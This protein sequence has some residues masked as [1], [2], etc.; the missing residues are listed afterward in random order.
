MV[1][2]DS[3]AKPA[4]TGWPTELQDIDT[5]LNK[6]SFLDVFKDH[7]TNDIVTKFVRDVVVQN[8]QGHD[9]TGDGR[10]L[11]TGDREFRRQA[12]RLGLASLGA[13]LQAN[14]TGPVLEGTDTSDAVF[15]SAYQEAIRCTKAPGAN[16]V[17]GLKRPIENFRKLCVRSLD[18]D[19]VSVYPYIPHIELFGFARFIFTSGNILPVDPPEA[20]EADSDDTLA[21]DLS[22]VRFRV[23]LW[24]YKLL[25][26]PSLGPGSL[27]TKSGRWTDV[28]TL[29]ETIQKSLDDVEASVTRV[30]E[31]EEGV[32]TPAWSHEHRIQFY[33]EKANAHLMLGSDKAARRALQWAT[34]KSGFVYALSGALG[35][36]TRFQEKDISQLVVLAK[37]L[38]ITVTDA[39][40]KTS[41]ESA[42]TAL[43]LNDDTLLERIDFKNESGVAEERTELPVQL[44]DI[45]PDNQPKLKPEDQII[46][47]TEATLKDT[48][49][50]SDALT[51]EEIL[52]FAVRVIDDKASNWQ[53]Y[54]Q[55][56][57]VRSRIELN[58][59]RTLERAV[60][61]MQAVVDQVIVDTQAPALA[62]ISKDAENRSGSNTESE[63]PLIEI[64]TTNSRPTGSA[65][66][67]KPTS[68]LPAPKHSESASAQERLQYVN[69]LA[70]PP[71]WHLESELAYAW[72][73]V[74]SLVS[75]T[76]IFKRLRLWAEVALCLASNA[77]S[78]DDRDAR[79]SGGEEKAR[80]IVRWRLFHRT[81]SRPDS[82]DDE[83]DLD[84]V[85]VDI[86]TLK[87]SDFRGPERSPAPPNAPRLF[88]ILG[89]LE[90]NPAHYE[91]AWEISNRRFARAQRS[92]GELYLRNQEW[93]KA[94]DAYA[95]AV[96]VNR[97]SPEMWSRLGD[98]ELRLGHFPDA[99]EAF[100]RAISTAGS[101][102]EG[103]EDARTWSNLGSALLSWYREA[104][105]ENKAS[106]EM[107]LKEESGDDVYDSDAK[108]S[109]RT[110]DD[111]EE[112]I[113]PSTAR[114]V[115][116]GK[117]PYKLLN[118]A[119]E[120]FKRGATIANSNWRIWDNVV[121]LAASLCPS[122]GFDDVILG[123]RN[124][125][126]I[127]KT[128]DALDV[129]ILTLLVRE[130]TGRA[131]GSGEGVGAV[132][133]PPRASLER[134]VIDLFE[135][136]VVPLLTATS[137][138]WSLVSR[139]RAWRRDWTGALEAAE[140]G[141]RAA[142]SGSGAGVSGD[143]GSSSLAP[144][145]AVSS[146]PG[147]AAAADWLQDAGAWDAVVQRT[148]EL[149]AAYENYGDK[150]ESVGSRWK[151]KARM[152]VRSVLGKGRESW[153]GSD[154]WRVLE[155]LLEELKG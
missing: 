59:S 77:N 88:C 107:R 123:T 141:W 153:E 125:L 136:D 95:A 67:K 65:T 118:D 30:V 26:Q 155:G 143:R 10:S 96:A 24:H 4:S 128:E 36:R 145:T 37:S 79:G 61:Q 116:L 80:A 39:S 35:K 22:W 73:S 109:R 87:V 94:R 104:A 3:A 130:I 63:V 121:T 102:G 84:D 7:S 8:R 6:M 91:R 93:T 126:R 68:F 46:L 106:R 92:L 147:T 9:E 50:P 112:G 71:R 58:R 31:N 25:T 47:L 5:G 41:S 76:E 13:F 1:S 48:F 54:T 29:Q 16:G 28:A 69:A 17:S 133:E 72:A 122:P 151:G 66:P 83:D 62:T 135:N 56:L 42:P 53:I 149:V 64:T 148:T 137:E 90:N 101:G 21:G 81:S 129:D 82:K 78:D 142:V 43:P 97:L 14:V 131:A 60:L 100:Q 11:N 138:P 75:A 49:S 140:K 38:Q 44:Q 146:S 33:L 89:D 57:L 40:E 114:A 134:K 45:V 105:A 23:H 85:D 115:R 119:L 117:Q 99:A 150:V 32:E 18:T 132:Y 2:R 127:R 51:S 27:F 152:S 108:R 86:S 74:G 70:S 120:A 110:T 111:K 34:E 113:M 55:A 144:T 124:V 98:I 20:W 19:G 15:A 154:G 103:G 52:P 12:I 139:L